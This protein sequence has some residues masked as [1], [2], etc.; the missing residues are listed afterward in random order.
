MLLL[1]GA[2]LVLM[3]LGLPVA[4]AMAT[5]SGQCSEVATVKAR[6]A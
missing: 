4:L 2:F 5:S 6:E 3:L 1:L